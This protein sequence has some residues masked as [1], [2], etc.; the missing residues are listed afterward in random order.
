MGPANSLAGRDIGQDFSR[1]DGWSMYHGSSVPGF[2]A[3]PHRGFETVTIVRKGLIDHADSLGAKARFGRGVVH[4]EM[5]PLL[6]QSAPNPLELFQIWLNLPA[7]MEY[8]TNAGRPGSLVK[9]PTGHS[10]GTDR[11]NCSDQAGEHQLAGGV[12]LSG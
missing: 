2:P 12:P 9:P 10:T 7:R 5:F 4:S 3:H 11:E 6:D 1:K 8:L